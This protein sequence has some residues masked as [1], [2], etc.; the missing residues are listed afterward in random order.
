[1]KRIYYLFFIPFIFYL[2]ACSNSVSENNETGSVEFSFSA[3]DLQRIAARS[4]GGAAAYKLTIALKG[5]YDSSKNETITDFTK[6]ISITFDDIPIGKNL[7]AEAQILK[8]V[9]GT[10]RLKMQG[11]SE[12]IKIAAG[13]N[14]LTLKL[15][16]CIDTPVVT[17]SNDTYY[18]DNTSIGSLDSYAFDSDGYYYYL[19]SQ[20]LH[21]TNPECTVIDLTES[22]SDM[23]AY[24]SPG[25]IIDLAKNELYYYAKNDMTL[26]LKKFPSLISEGKTDNAVSFNVNLNNPSDFYHSLVSV[27]N[28]VLYEVGP[29]YSG[30]NPDQYL[31]AVTLQAGQGVW[32][33]TPDKIINL[34][35]KL[36]ETNA[37]GINNSNITDMLYYDNAVYLTYR[38]YYQ[39]FNAETTDS[40]HYYIWHTQEENP[41]CFEP[42]YSRGAVVKYDLSSNA[43]K[44]LGW[45]NSSMNLSGTKFFTYGQIYCNYTNYCKQKIHSPEYYLTITS[46]DFTS[47]NTPD[48]YAPVSQK[49]FFGPQK[50]IA[51]KPKQLVISD[52]GIAFY[53]DNYGVKYKNS[54]RIVTINL[55]DF[56]IA[57]STETMATFS[58]EREHTIACGIV[59]GRY[60]HF[61]EEF[62]WK[63]NADDEEWQI[64]EAT[65]Q[66]GEDQSGN[67]VYLNAHTLYM[68]IPQDDE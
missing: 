5:E 22:L 36:R 59:N 58:D 56:A 11:K 25:I 18:L 54:N 24:M 16:R 32:N 66:D 33:E 6:P 50:F 2:A 68:G 38:H 46:S 3:S 43:I 49:A 1:M 26:E 41:D 61:D 30:D 28:G 53:S 29:S 20:T 35:Q 44:V 67:P 7:F 8:D 42:L 62:Y 27:N 23:S 45:T 65:I 47:V 13:E 48:I 52:D 17:Y 40:Y 63:Y 10:D 51:I 12:T 34:S 4:G 55:E 39:D 31:V 64:A 14:P 57:Y 60:I 9:N 21:S 37:E 19:V 15:E